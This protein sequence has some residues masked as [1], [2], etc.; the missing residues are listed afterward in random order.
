VKRNRADKNIT[1]KKNGEKAP[2]QSEERYRAA[3][4]NM[5]DEAIMTDTEGGR[6]CRMEEIE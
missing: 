3:M 5:G 6:S 2:R 1:A 4:M